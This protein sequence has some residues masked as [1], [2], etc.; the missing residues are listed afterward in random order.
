MSEDGAIVGESKLDHQPRKTFSASGKA[1]SPADFDLK[2]PVQLTGTTTAIADSVRSIER[3]DIAKSGHAGLQ[4]EYRFEAKPTPD[5]F[6]EERGRTFLL[7]RA[8]SAYIARKKAASLGSLGEAAEL[9]S[10]HQ[11]AME[12]YRNHRRAAITPCPS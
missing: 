2:G 4:A 1:A 3:P 10:G 9:Q 8:R 5:K 6:Y 12:R 11:D 7:A